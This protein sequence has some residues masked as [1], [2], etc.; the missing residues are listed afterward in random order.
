VEQHALFSSISS[1]TLDQLL[2]AFHSWIDGAL[3]TKAKSYTQYIFQKP[4][5]LSAA[6]SHNWFV[7][8]E[9][10]S[11]PTS[12]G[13]KPQAPPMHASLIPA[14]EAHRAD[15]PQ[16]SDKG[17]RLQKRSSFFRDFSA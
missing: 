14:V 7:D 16:C 10:F 9:R 17:P 3:V 5:V 1:Q 13:C 2:Y 6:T 8:W 12:V 15:L 4:T 11:V